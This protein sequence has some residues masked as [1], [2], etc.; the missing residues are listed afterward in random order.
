MAVK[1]VMWYQVFAKGK[2]KNALLYYYWEETREIARHS[3][4]TH[5][6]HCR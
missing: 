3:S 6:C 2:K 5:V 4:R 1:V